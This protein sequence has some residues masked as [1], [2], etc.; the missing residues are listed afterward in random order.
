MLSGDKLPS[1]CRTTV[2]QFTD[3]P[4]YCDFMAIFRNCC[5]IGLFQICFLLFR[6]IIALALCGLFV[7]TEQRGLSVTTVS[8]AKSAEPIVI[9]FGMLTQVGPS[10]PCIRLGSRY[11]C[12][13]LILTGI[14]SRFSSTPPSTVLSGPDVGISPHAVYQCC[15]WLAA[16]AVESHIKCL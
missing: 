7:Q 10:E 16:E 2:R 5:N 14:K 12:E 13:G 9:P 8:P 15:D 11:P 1:A 6:R 4:G 3:P